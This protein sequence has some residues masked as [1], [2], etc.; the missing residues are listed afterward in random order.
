MEL[1]WVIS[2]DFHIICVVVS[3][4]YCIFKVDT[5]SANIIV[6]IF[7]DERL[8]K[9]SPASCLPLLKKR[10]HRAMGHGHRSQ[11]CIFKYFSLFFS[12]SIS[13]WRLKE[14]FF[15]IC[16]FFFSFG[17]RPYCQCSNVLMALCPEVTL[18]VLK[19]PYV[20][21]RIN[22]G[23]ATSN[24]NTLTLNYFSTSLP[25]IFKCVIISFIILSFLLQKFLLM[26]FCLQSGN[27]D[28]PLWIGRTSSRWGTIAS[29]SAQ[30]R[31][32]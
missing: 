25:C 22:L 16:F 5:G 32:A 12:V 1:V 28:S 3:L 19:D 9:S 4:V 15:S 7:R 21:P 29:P 30:Q 6:P 27:P 20:I 26:L 31:W 10:G 23:L 11:Q 13:G 24:A 2:H 17:F 18:A 14:A 8:E